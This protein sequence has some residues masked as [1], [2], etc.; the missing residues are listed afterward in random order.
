MGKVAGG[1]K[2]KYDK[3]GSNYEKHIPDTTSKNRSQVFSHVNDNFEKMYSS[4]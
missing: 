4:N 3:F 1:Q 2:Q